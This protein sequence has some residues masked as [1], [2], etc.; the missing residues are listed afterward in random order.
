[1]SSWIKVIVLAVALLFAGLFAFDRCNPPQVGDIDTVYV[2]TVKYDTI[3]RV[4]TVFEK[5]TRTI[6]YRQ[7]LPK[8]DTL[9]EQYDTTK[10]TRYYQRYQTN[11][12][13]ID[14]TSW[15]VGGLVK[16]EVKAAKT[17]E[18]VRTVTRTERIRIPQRGIFLGIQVGTG[19][20]V[21]IDY[22][23]R[24]GWQ[25]GVGYSN[26]KGNDFYHLNIRKKIF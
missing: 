13:L 18:I 1:M 6:Y 10:V 24:K 15:V 4:D 12:Y 25:I 5:V 3:V 11:G 22:L 20:G 2:E 21:N 9:K 19:V 23:N 14:V 8:P 7:T 17:S 16:Q 26:V